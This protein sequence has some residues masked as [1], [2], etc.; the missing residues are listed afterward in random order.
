MSAWLDGAH[1]WHWWL[2]GV[3]LLVLEMLAPGVFFLWLGVAAGLIGLLVWLVPAVPWQSQVLGFAILSVSLALL[4]R[5]WLKRHPIQTDQPRLN[6]RGEQYVDRIFTLDDPIS[7]GTGKL[8]V[9]DTTWKI[10]GEDCPSGTRVRVIGVDGVILLVE[11]AQLGPKG[12]G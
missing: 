12:V 7:N 11:A 3:L 8:R 6:R 4:A 5:V 2:L 9:D 1:F 10:R